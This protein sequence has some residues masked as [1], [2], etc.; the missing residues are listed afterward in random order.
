MDT[1]VQKMGRAG[2]DGKLSDELILLKTN[3]T[4]LKR[5]DGELVKLAKDDK[6]CRHEMIC[7]SYLEKH[8]RISPLH[9]CCDICEKTCPC[10][11]DDCPRVHPGF[12]K[13]TTS[14]SDS[15]E[16][17]HREVSDNERKI[18]KEKL[19]TYRFN[20]SSSTQ[21]VDSNII[22]GLTDDIIENLVKKC[23]TVFTVDDVMHKSGLV[24]KNCTRY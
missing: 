4:Q 13:L 23:E 2:R 1:F 12:S 10:E 3:K 17:M 21:V 18:L 8:T 9:D 7:S 5:V 19:V 15:C 14:D 11:T 20:L 24:S 22:H 16:E 6:A